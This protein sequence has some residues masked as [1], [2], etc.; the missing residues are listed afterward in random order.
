MPLVSCPGCRY[1]LESTRTSCHEC[2]ER[3]V[4]AF[5]SVKPSMAIVTK[6]LFCSLHALL[7]ALMFIALKL[8]AYVVYLQNLFQAAMD[9]DS[10]NRRLLRLYYNFVN[11]ASKDAPQFQS[12]PAARFGGTG[13]IG[14]IDILASRP[15][16]LASIAVHCLIVLLAIV[17]LTV[18]RLPRGFKWAFVF[19]AGLQIGFVCLIMFRTLR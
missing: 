3:L 6:V 14:V 1:P 9:V 13:D 2:G 18:R 17:S 15:D 4:L 5:E 8:V 16:V 7:L 11:G 19:A 12:F 10:E